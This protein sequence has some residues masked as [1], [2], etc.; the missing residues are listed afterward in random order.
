MGKNPKPAVKRFLSECALFLLLLTIGAYCLD[1]LLSAGLKKSRAGDLGIWNE[2]YAGNINAEIVIY[3][4][5]RAAVHFDPHIIAEGTGLSTYNL[6]IDGHNFW[7]QY[8]RHSLFLKHNPKPKVILQ[9]IDVSTLERRNNLYNP[10][11]F[12]PYVLHDGQVADFTSVYEGFSFLDYHV[13]LLRYYGRRGAV[14]AA[15]R[16]L[17]DPSADE[18][19]R[20]L[21]YKGQEL[22]WN[23]DWNRVKQDLGF[24]E[25]LLDLPTVALFETYL[26]ECRDLGIKVIF[27]NTPEF[28]E[29]HDLITNRAEVL[30]VFRKMSEKFGIPLLDYS[31]SPI[32]FQTKYFYNSQHMNREGAELFTEDLARALRP[33]L[34][35]IRASGR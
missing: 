27:V 33:L 14:L 18:P 19:D 22:S 4:S 24:R 20:V 32:S 28:V 8:L 7:L 5:S 11:Q 31:N 29:A 26:R 6:G 34:T 1:A 17:W 23:E 13:P 16:S 30:D 10:E 2:I 21:G 12:L 15:M 35:G 3:G 9:S 25:A